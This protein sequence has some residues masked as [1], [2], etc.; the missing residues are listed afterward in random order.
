MTKKQSINC[1]KEN[2]RFNFLFH[3]LSIYFFII[4]FSR[5]LNHDPEL[6]P[7]P[8]RFDP[9]RHLND[10][11]EVI[12]SPYLFAFGA[13]MKELVHFSPIVHCILLYCKQY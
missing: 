10:E 1:R 9:T 7:D 6:W 8:E 11:G 3:I 12:K 4:F 5:G 13:G 2:D